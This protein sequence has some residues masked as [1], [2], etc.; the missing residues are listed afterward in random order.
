[1]KK[2]V[3]KGVDSFSV[4]IADNGYIVDYSGNDE[5]GDWASSKRVVNSQNELLAL[6]AKICQEM[7]G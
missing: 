6:I 1:M 5:N 7:N 2:E 4:D 3:V